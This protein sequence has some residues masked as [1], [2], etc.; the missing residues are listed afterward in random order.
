MCI[1]K[2]YIAWT[3]RQ[4]DMVIA[5]YTFLVYL[6]RWLKCTIVIARCPSSV[7]RPSLIFHISTSPLKLQTGIQR[8][9]TGCKI[10]T[11]FTKCVLFGQIGKTSSRPSLWF[12]EIFW[13]SLKLLT[14]IQ[15]HMTGSRISNVLYQ[16]C[17]I[18]STNFVFGQIE[19]KKTRWPPWPLIG[20]HIFDFSE[21]AERNSTKLDRK[22]DLN[23][24]YQVC[25]FLADRKT[26]MV[27]TASDWLRLYR[28]LWNRWTELSKTRQ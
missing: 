14:E 24:L 17:Q 4:T 10:S 11:S 20:W 21:A 3:Y 7:V 6:N 19:K 12:A 9:F 2:V 25:V 1:K 26:K 15:R 8:N 27:A 5:I 16:V 13:T 22:Q 28:L 23:V 18:S